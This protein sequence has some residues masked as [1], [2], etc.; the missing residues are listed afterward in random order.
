[1]IS[2]SDLHTMVKPKKEILTEMEVGS[3]TLEVRMVG[4]GACV[5]ERTESVDYLR[6]LVYV[7]SAFCFQR[8]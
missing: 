1:M 2:Q 3:K 5:H 7:F 4:I 8:P 6:V